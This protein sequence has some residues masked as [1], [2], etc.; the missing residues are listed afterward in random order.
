MRPMHWGC[1][2]HWVRLCLQSTRQQQQLALQQQLLH[3]PLLDV[4]AVRVVRLHPPSLTHALMLLCSLHSAV[5]PQFAQP[6][7]GA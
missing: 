5:M 4:H 7:E 3:P 1:W 2:R 6:V